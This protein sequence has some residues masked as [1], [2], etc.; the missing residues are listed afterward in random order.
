M[1]I[2]VQDKSIGAVYTMHFGKLI[3]VAELWQ[4]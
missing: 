1:K 2:K 4:I 3:Q